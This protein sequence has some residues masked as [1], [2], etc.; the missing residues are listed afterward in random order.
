MEISELYKIYKS[1]S[2]I[3]TDTRKIKKGGLFFALKGENFNG[4]LFAAKAISDGCSFAIID[5]KKI[6]TNDKF[7]LVKN[8][9]ETLQNLARH[10][11]KQLSIPIIGITGTNGKTTSKELIHAVLKSELNSYATKGNLNNHIGV[12]LSILEITKEHEIAIIEMGAN[13]EKEI[14]FLCDIAKPT[15]GVITNIGSAHLEGF[16]DH[17]GVINAKNE[18]F[19][20][21]KKNNG[22]LFVNDDDNLLLNLSQKIE[23]ITYGNNGF[24]KGFI[25][26]NTPYLS[27]KFSHTEINSQL[28]GEYQFS[29]I[30]LAVCIGNKFNIKDLNIQKAIE[31]Y[32]PKNN[33]SEILKTKDNLLIL[34]AY[35]ANPSSMKAMITSFSKQDYTNKLCILG[36]M[37][38]L[39]EYT[40]KEHSAILDLIDT[41]NLEIILIGKEFSKISKEAFK[42][43][44]AFEIFLKSNPIKNKTIL[45][46]GSRGIELEKLQAML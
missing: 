2:S 24:C 16:K 19:N 10:H 25:T 13:H 20:F 31:N 27:I 21:I 28:I 29:N 43:R 18:L 14:E 30:M 23:R 3:C 6:A 11:R 17:Q 36:D 45:L 46:K 41:L 33:R 38:E 1:K 22:L 44:N 42:D 32:T 9:L 8:V 7:I 4:N 26:K 40:I 12:P 15:H 5:E 35:N 34:D 37:L 39:G